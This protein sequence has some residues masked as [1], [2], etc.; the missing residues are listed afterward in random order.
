ML[1]FHFALLAPLLSLG[2]AL[3]T[4]SPKSWG[5]AFAEA[6]M[7]LANECGNEC[8]AVLR[9]VVNA[10]SADPHVYGNGGKEAF[11]MKSMSDRGLKRL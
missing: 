11:V 6:E 3:R 10:S 9:S 2:Y 5:D 7:M 4:G 8:V 1:R